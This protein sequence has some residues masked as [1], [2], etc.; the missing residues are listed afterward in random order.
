MARMRAAQVTAGKGQFQIVEREAA[1]PAS[2]LVRVKVQASG[3]CHSDALTKEG[4]W[5]GIHY[6]RVPGHEVA[7][8]VDACSSDIVGLAVGD[9]VGLGWHGGDC[10]QCASCRRGDYVTCQFLQIPGSLL[11]G[12]LPG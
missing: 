8:V 9:R 12:N 2:G 3:I 10:G 7:G 4:L 6:P 1:E 5:P 11:D